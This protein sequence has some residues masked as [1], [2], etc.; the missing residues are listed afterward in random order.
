MKRDETTP[1]KSHGRPP[2]TQTNYDRI[3]TSHTTYGHG[4]TDGPDINLYERE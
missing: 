2:Q 1:Q 3:D 4:W